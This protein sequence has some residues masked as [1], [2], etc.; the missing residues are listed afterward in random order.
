MFIIDWQQF[1]HRSINWLQILFYCTLGWQTGQKRHCDCIVGYS[2][3]YWYLKN[4]PR[5]IIGLI[6]CAVVCWNQ[7]HKG[8]VTAVDAE[9]NDWGVGLHV[10]Q[11][12]GLKWHYDRTKSRWFPLRHTAELQQLHLSYLGKFSDS[13]FLNLNLHL[14]SKSSSCA[15]SGILEH[16]IL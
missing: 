8:D 2:T 7:G 13:D 14:K 16:T 6:K 5:G 10:S 4:Q 15:F 12:K 9:R 11:L 3:K 1:N